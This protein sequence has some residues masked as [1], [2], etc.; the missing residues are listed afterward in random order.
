MQDALDDVLHH[1]RFL[2]GGDA[3]ARHLEPKPLVYVVAAA[4]L[5]VIL[6]NLRANPV[7]REWQVT[8]EVLR[9]C[10]ELLRRLRNEAVDVRE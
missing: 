5:P 6:V 3:I 8:N 10:D 7:R 9:V 2:C 1:C 4:S